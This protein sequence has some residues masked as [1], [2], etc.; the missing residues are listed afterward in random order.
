[1]NSR[2][3][4]S[5]STA[6]RAP[7]AARGSVRARSIAFPCLLKADS[8]GFRFSAD[9]ARLAFGARGLFI[10]YLARQA[11]ERSD[12]AAAEMIFGELIANVAQHAPG[13]IDIRV[14]WANTVPVLMVLDRGPGYDM[15]DAS[16]PS[17]DSES[18][19]GLYIVASLG[20]NLRVTRRGRRTVTSIELPVR[21]QRRPSR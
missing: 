1:M 19:R 5:G 6:A 16:L 18:K 9:D 4:T 13:P 3:G 17:G 15:S 14:S 2:R 12:L 8:D 7:S 21:R 20:R 10:S 11:D